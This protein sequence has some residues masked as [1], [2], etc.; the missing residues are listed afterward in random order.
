MIVPDAYVY[1][2]ILTFAIDFM[3]LSPQCFYIE[4]LI[5]NVMVFRDEAFGRK[6]GL[7]EV[8]KVEPP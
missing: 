1:F 4:A 2:H 8:I 7:D 5:H 3:F 6:L